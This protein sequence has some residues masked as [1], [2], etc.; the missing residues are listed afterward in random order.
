MNTLPGC[1][2]LHSFDV[3]VFSADDGNKLSWNFDVRSPKNMALH[4]RRPPLWS[5]GQSS[6]IQI[7]RSGFD[8]RYYQIFWAVVG[9]QRGPLS[10]V[11]TIEELLERKSSGS[12]LENR[13]TAVEDP[14]RWLRDT[15]LSAK[16]GTNFVDKPLSFGRIL[17]SRTKATE[18]FIFIYLLLYSRKTGKFQ[19]LIATFLI[20]IEAWNCSKISSLLHHPT[21]IEDLTI[22]LPLSKKTYQMSKIS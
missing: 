14:P 4:S 11:S 15:P 3:C 2:K 1:V 9:L 6:W 22:D 5:S 10:L 17:C 18:L 7:Q 21:Q 16:V 12:S 13:D 19:S 8:S 20:L